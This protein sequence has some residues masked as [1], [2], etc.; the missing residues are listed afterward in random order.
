MRALILAGGEGTRLRPLTLTRPKPAMTLVDRPFIAYMVDWVGRHGITDVVV[1]CG[2]GSD[3]V[4]AALDDGR[5]ATTRIAYVEEPEPLGTAGPLR[6]AADRGL[7]DDRFLVLNGDL[8]ADLDLSALLRVHEERGAVA[9]LAL[10]EV[11]DPSSYG[12]VR[13]ANG[14]TAPGARPTGNG[15]EVL[16]FLEKPGLAEV[17]TDEVNAGAYVLEPSVIDL[18]PRGRMFSIER[19]VFPRLVGRGLYGHRL[20]GYWMDVGT[21]ERY[22][23]ASWDVLEGRVRTEVGDRLDGTGLL[24]AEAGGVDPGASV[25][26]P[27]LLDAGVAVGTGAAVG[28]RAVIATGSVI[29]ERARVVSSVVLGD[30]RIGAEA[31]VQQSI[32]APAV[33]VGEGARIQP[34]SVI[35][36]GARIE[37]GADI[38]PGSRVD[39]GGVAA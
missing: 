17:D 33:V 31:D 26:P 5:R 3:A 13:R 28:P 22:L 15:G 39:P 6:L 10:H 38:E 23:D 36:E 9:T 12:L 7:L 16:E 1:A 35:G 32:L 34:G 30:C 24:V 19:E 11:G 14:P 18:I 2:F 25:R 29:G 37:P 21:P 8:L 20:D 27:A 4:R